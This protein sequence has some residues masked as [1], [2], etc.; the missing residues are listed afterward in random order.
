MSPLSPLLLQGGGKSV[1]DGKSQEPN[2]ITK[3]SDQVLGHNHL[4]NARLYYCSS[5]IFS[6]AGSVH[7]DLSLSMSMTKLGHVLSQ[8]HWCSQDMAKL[9]MHMAILLS[10]RTW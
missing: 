9:G 6:H 2:T 7:V 10:C 4:G 3:P 8:S 1:P 5:P